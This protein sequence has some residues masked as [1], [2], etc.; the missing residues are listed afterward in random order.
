MMFVVSCSGLLKKKDEDAGAPEAGVTEVAADAAPEPTPAALASNE[1]DVARFPDETKLAGVN[2]TLLRTYNVREA[3]PN[4]T[5]VVGLNKGT[6]ATQI[7]SRDKYFLITFDSPTNPGTR[8]MGWVHRD[9]FSAV[10]QD[11]GPLTCPAGEIALFGDTP[12]CGKLCTLDSECPAGQACKG[13][14]NKLAAGKAGAP[15]QVCTVFHAHDAG[16]PDAGGPKKLGKADAGGGGGVDAGPTLPPDPGRDTVN[17]TGG[18]CPAGFVHVKK[19]NKCHRKCTN[20]QKAA[21]EC[22]NKPYF[23]VGCEGQNVC[24]ESKEQCK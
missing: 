11:A 19:T 22:K 20:A 4:G 9:A 7:A 13:S 21:Q 18:L 5:L 24:S 3:P 23:C 12:F 14:A 6:S 1:G 17:A 8:L 16:A 15:V 10:V 2:A